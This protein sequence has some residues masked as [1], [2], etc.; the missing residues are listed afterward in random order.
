MVRMMI[1]SLGLTLSAMGCVPSN[2]TRLDAPQTQVESLAGMATIGAVDPSESENPA[3]PS[4]AADATPMTEN[5][6]Q[7]M[8]GAP[9]PIDGGARTGGV[10]I[11]ERDG[12]GGMAED[13][14]SG[15]QSQAGTR[16]ASGG[17]S[18][19]L[20]DAS[21]GEVAVIAQG[22]EQAAGHA[23]QAAS[24]AGGEPEIRVELA[25]QDGRG[26]ESGVGGISTRHQAGAP[27]SDA[28]GMPHDMH[29]GDVVV[30]SA[31]DDAMWAHDSAG[32]GTM[33]DA[34]GDDASLTHERAGQNAEEQAGGDSGG[35]DGEVHDAP[36]FMVPCGYRYWNR[37]TGQRQQLLLYTYDDAWRVIRIVTEQDGIRWVSLRTQLSDN[38]LELF[39]EYVD[40][41]GLVQMRTQTTYNANAQVM[42]LRVEYPNTP[43]MAPAVTTY[44]YE[45]G[46]M[47]RVSQRQGDDETL[48]I[49]EYDLSGNIISMIALYPT[50]LRQEARYTYDADQRLITERTVDINGRVTNARI[51]YQIDG[52]GLLLSEEKRDLNTGGLIDRSVYERALTGELLRKVQSDA[53]GRR[54]LTTYYACEGL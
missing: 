18:H 24:N 8:S 2:S 41:N 19:R 40:A 53:T 29:S 20:A 27:S 51:T 30:D 38:G 12:Q 13:D 14:A 45:N 42:R 4:A 36:A 9:T 54:Y 1:L 6:Q 34:A 31:G 10:P 33:S 39:G 47:V 35:A 26:G 49:Y 25:G 23:S 5:T 22:G 17:E 7:P 21:A 44:E 3:R 11:A 28:A 46:R 50:G 52:R 16:A 43:A 32:A 37:Q 15:G 48:T